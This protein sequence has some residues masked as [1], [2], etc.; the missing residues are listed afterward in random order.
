MT[1][2]RGGIGRVAAASMLLAALG[3]GT[4]VQGASSAGTGAGP[5]T[6]DSSLRTGAA[7]ST[8]PGSRE[9]G[10]SAGLAPAIQ[11]AP[12]DVPLGSSRTP[13]ATDAGTSGRAALAANGP[14]V[15]TTTLTVGVAYLQNANEA[16]AAIG[17]K[18]IEVGD[19]T[20]QAKI[21]VDDL[22]RRGGIAGRKVVPLFFGV[23]P[24]SSQ[25]YAAEA[26]AEC[27]YF[28]EDHKVLAVIDGT[29]AVGSLARPCLEQ[30]HVAFVADNSVV[31]SDVVPHEFDPD[32]IL[33]SRLFAAL[34]PSLTRQGWFSPWNKTTGTGD[35]TTKA[36][37]GIVTADRPALNRALDHVL[38]PLLRAAGYRVDPADVYRITP[39]GGFSDDG[40][41]VAAIQSAVLKFNSDGV[42][43]VV[44]TDGNGSISLL[45]NNYA[46]SQHYFP[47]YGGSTGN[48]WQ[49]LLAAGD[50]QPATLAGSMGIAWMPMI[51]LPYHDGDGDYPN[52]ERRRCL[53]LMRAQGQAAT[54][55]TVA[56]SQ[57]VACDAFWL[58]QSA[59][60][61][62][63][64]R[65]VNTNVLLDRVD[66][67]GG[68]FQPGLALADSFAPHHHDGVGAGYD[69][70]FGTTCGCYSYHGP[71]HTMTS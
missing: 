22:N 2:S 13:T 8:S 62:D 68:G 59:L 11:S 35:G 25:T 24:Q 3:C 17:G 51:D 14:G 63:V 1:G 65:P 31:I 16:N 39:P 18:G 70:S 47:R 21:I 38:L 7:G 45:F 19:P 15:T 54:S 57:L 53:G 12:P 9:A 46:Y 58:L 33:W 28:T 29:Q 6:T 40:S 27:T 60:R 32:S 37:I 43:H 42:D 56:A 36:K 55:A 64:R 20:L 48:F 67:L 34:V 30:H 41:T 26:Q 44:L 50:I 5:A 61:T 69:M 49:T 23:D 4:T 71:Q 66:A 52:S 10:G